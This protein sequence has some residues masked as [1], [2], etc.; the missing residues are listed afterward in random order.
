MQSL[1]G[2]LQ[3]CT[4][5]K[6]VRGGGKRFSVSSGV[7]VLYPRGPKVLRMIQN[8]YAL[9]NARQR[10][11]AAFAGFLEAMRQMGKL[12]IDMELREPRD[13]ARPLH[14]AAP[15]IDPAQRI[16]NLTGQS[17]NKGS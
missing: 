2:H 14:D 12:E 10:T 7:F 17:R 6:R 15:A 9:L 1:R 11:E 4:E 3:H 5:R 16:A 13:S 8:E